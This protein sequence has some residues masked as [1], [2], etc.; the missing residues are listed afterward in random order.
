MKKPFRYIPALL[1]PFLVKE[2]P[3]SRVIVE[4][5]PQCACFLLTFNRAGSNGMNF[6]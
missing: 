1:F 2:G 3:F 4:T 5:V 6:E